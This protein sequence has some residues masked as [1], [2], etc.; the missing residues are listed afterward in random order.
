MQSR[1]RIDTKT[2]D[3]E[4]YRFP[5][6]LSS[7]NS[8][9]NFTQIASETLRLTLNWMDNKEKNRRIGAVKMVRRE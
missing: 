4:I 3:Y 1:N 6:G 7:D 8:I 5:N 9:Q 2:L